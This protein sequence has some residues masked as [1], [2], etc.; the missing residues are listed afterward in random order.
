M[1]SLEVAARDRKVAF[2]YLDAPQAPLFRYLRVPE[3]QK[4]FSRLLRKARAYEKSCRFCWF[5]IGILP[6]FDGVWWRQF[7]VVFFEQFNPNP[8]F[9]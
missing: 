9:H 7:A 3:F 4:G 5:G 1:E 2:L 6:H 8:L